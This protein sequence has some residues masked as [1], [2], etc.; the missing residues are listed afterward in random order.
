M[1]GRKFDIKETVT[2]IAELFRKH[3]YHGTTLSNIKEASGLGKGSFYH[4]FPD[5]KEEVARKVLKEVHE[6]F[7]QNVYR[8]L[9]QPPYDPDSIQKMFDK[10]SEFFWKGN[11][12]CI[13]GSFALYDV[14]DAFPEEI[15]HYFERWIQALTFNLRHQGIPTPKSKKLAIDAVAVIQGALVLTRALENPAVFEDSLKRTR[16]QLMEKLR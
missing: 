12:V 3:G 5:G 6:W 8:P 13:P 9:E 1:P 14:R 2:I 4:H 15:R 7:E 16:Y 10:T 11:R